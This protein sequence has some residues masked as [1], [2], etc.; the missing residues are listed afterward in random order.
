[1]MNILIYCIISGILLFLF[2]LF[3]KPFYESINSLEWPIIGVK[4]IKASVQFYTKQ[5]GFKLVN[6]NIDF[7]NCNEIQLS[8]SD[9][10]ITLKPKGN[11]PIY[12]NSKKV[13]KPKR[14]NFKRVGVKGNPTLNIHI[15][16]PDKYM[17]ESKEKGIKCYEEDKKYSRPQLKGFYIL[18]NENNR[19]YFYRDFHGPYG[20]SGPYGWHWDW[21]WNIC[22]NTN[23]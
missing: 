17:N 18:D 3:S 2:W 19:V 11:G 7:N 20:L 5:L 8:F 13:I 1:M 9:Y 15:P 16:D 6:E 12:E 10:L 4:D 21:N 14:H 22:E 23:A